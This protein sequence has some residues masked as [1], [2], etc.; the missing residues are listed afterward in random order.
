MGRTLLRPLSTDGGVLSRALRRAVG[1]A[2]D[3]STT[4]PMDAISWR[5][6]T[7][8]VKS[9]LLSQETGSGTCANRLYSAPEP[10]PRHLYDS[11]LTSRKKSSRS[12]Q[13]S[14]HSAQ[15]LHEDNSAIA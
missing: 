13:H 15:N 3:P 6:L 10:A 7:S 8:I 14:V 11:F 9:D 2:N 5:R 4:P 12:G 1:R